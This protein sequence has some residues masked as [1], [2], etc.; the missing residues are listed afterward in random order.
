MNRTDIRDLFKEFNVKITGSVKENIWDKEAGKSILFKSKGTNLPYQNCF[1]LTN[2]DIKS[3]SYHNILYLQLKLGPKIFF[4]NIEIVTSNHQL[5]K[6]VITNQ[7]REFKNDQGKIYLLLPPV[8]EASWKTLVVD[9]SAVVKATSGDQYWTV[10]RINLYGN[11]SIAGIYWTSYL[12]TK[13]TNQL[14]LKNGKVL[15]LT[16]TGA[17]SLE[18]DNGDEE[19]IEDTYTKIKKYDNVI[20]KYDT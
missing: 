4:C 3:K 14:I 10:R 16:G 13:G 17:E 8:T 5:Y 15:L 6:C 1:E 7:R 20:Y 18:E 2:P 19:I 9:V 11:L 12:S